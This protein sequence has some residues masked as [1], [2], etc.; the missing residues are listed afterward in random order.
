MI[1]PPERTVSLEDRLDAALTRAEMALAAR[2]AER[3]RL[4][5]VRDAAQAAKAE[6]D[7]LLAGTGA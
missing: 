2:D 3:L 5:A 7:A 1:E 6:L 4:R